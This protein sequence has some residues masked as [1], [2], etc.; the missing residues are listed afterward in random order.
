[1]TKTGGGGGKKKKSR[2]SAE[3]YFSVKLLLALSLKTL[4]VM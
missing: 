2:G 4:F 1:M 3:L